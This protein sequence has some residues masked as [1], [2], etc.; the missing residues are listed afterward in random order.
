MISVIIVNYKSKEHLGKCIESILS[1]S[2]EENVEIIVV[3]NDSEE[4]LEGSLGDNIKIINNGE[5]LGFSKASNIG[6][7]A[8][9]GEILLFLN[10]DAWISEGKIKA[11]KKEFEDPAIGIIGADIRD[12]SGFPQ[13]WSFGKKVTVFQILKNNLDLKSN[14]ESRTKKKEV[15]W[16][17]GAGLFIKADLFRQLGGFDDNF[18]VYFEDADLCLRASKAGKKILFFPGIKIYHLEGASNSGK[19]K[20]KELYYKSQDYYLEKNFGAGSAKTVR[21][22]R[23]VFKKNG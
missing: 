15:G 21:F 8:A 23:K 19:K 3:N 7:K 22:L 14:K 2:G 17:T 10:P 9:R 12:K 20:Q 1:G 5:N 18:F 11:V 16:V 4:R 13:K 6:A